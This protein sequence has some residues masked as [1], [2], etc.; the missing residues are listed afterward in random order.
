MRNVATPNFQI[1]PLKPPSPPYEPA[2]P[3]MPLT[4]RVYVQESC[5]W[6]YKTSCYMREDAPD[7]NALNELGAA[8]WELVGIASQDANVTFYFKRPAR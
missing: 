8:G 3:T 6:E 2:V 1:P 7:E 5:K 4:G